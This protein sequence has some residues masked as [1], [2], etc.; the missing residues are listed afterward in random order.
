MDGL[1]SQDCRTARWSLACR[2][3]SSVR[4]TR[5]FSRLDH[6]NHREASLH[7]SSVCC[8]R[9]PKLRVS[10]WERKRTR[11]DPRFDPISI[12]DATGLCSPIL[13][14]F[15]PSPLGDPNL[16][17]LNLRLSF[18]YYCFF[19]LS[20]SVAGLVGR[21]SILI[22]PPS[23][24]SPHP[25]PRAALHSPFLFLSPFFTPPAACP[26][27]LLHL[28]SL[29]FSVAGCHSLTLFVFS[30]SADLRQYLLNP[31]RYTT[32]R[33]FSI[34][35]AHP[36]RDRFHGF[37]RLESQLRWSCSYPSRATSA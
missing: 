6:T 16:I 11:L 19:F 24:L 34:S 10:E 28:H 12:H 29:T 35:T 18:H 20:F 2:S 32:L 1:R 23:L 22:H 26:I 5:S 9:V 27:N 30:P 14:L 21:P 33:T 4:R 3:R 36:Y 7:R 31:A 37:S 17:Y 25:L 13:V 8:L 15:L